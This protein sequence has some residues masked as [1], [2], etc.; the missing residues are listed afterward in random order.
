MSAGKRVLLAEQRPAEAG[1]R[2]GLGLRL[3]GLP[4]ARATAAHELTLTTPPTITNDEQRDEVLV[5]ARS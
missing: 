3:R 5:V 1:E 2:L 4:C